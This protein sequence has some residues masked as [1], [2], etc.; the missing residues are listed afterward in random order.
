[1]GLIKAAKETV[2]KLLG[3]QWREY[4]YCEALPADVLAV[5]GVKRV[6][7]GSSNTKGADNIISNGSIIA[8]AD[9]QCMMI[10]EQGA[11]VEFTAEPGEFQWDAST[12]PSIFV[13]SLGEN[14]KAT[15]EVVKKRFTMG[16]DT[17][18]DQRVYYFNTKEIIGNK[19]GTPAPVPFRVVDQRAGIDI[20][21]GIRCFGEYSYK[22]TDPMLFYKNVC[23]N[24]SSSYTRDE[25]DSQL[26]SEFMTAL[27]PTFAAIGEMGIRYSQ[28]P[29]HTTDM[30]NVIN[31]I[32][33]EQ[34]S[35]LRGISIVSVGVSSL[36][37]NEDDEK[38]LKELQ[39]NAAFVNTN[40]AAA[41]YL[42][43]QNEAMKA[44]AAN[45]GGAMNGFIG[46]GMAMNVGANNIQGLYNMAAQQ[47]AQQMGQYA[48]GQPSVQQPVQPAAAVQGW[49]CQCGAVNQ[50]NF[51]TQCGAK[52]PA[53]APL[54]KCD[55]CGW[56]PEDPTN[57]PKFC[58]NCGD[59]FDDNDKVN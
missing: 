25:I 39:K 1:M 45:E 54:Y 36:T 40:L 47:N 46:M 59:P 49:T 50:G 12:E 22:L 8:V 35:K 32:L 6:S 17:G 56:Q 23:G 57:P 5:K 34:W 31:D 27:Q 51:C 38:M 3:D 53:G 4:F 16:G 7:A 15:W 2:S 19:Y 28:L 13:G 58:P 26:K 29:A 14:L 18:K 43:A 10:V 37:A 41:N 33:S 30:A 24:I 20:D 9:G 11:I 48:Q 21:V 42:G 52:R 44:A 55:K